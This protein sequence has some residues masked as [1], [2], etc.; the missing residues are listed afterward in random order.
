MLIKNKTKTKEILPH[1]LD[2][3]D[4]DLN[5]RDLKII[6]S[7]YYFEVII[8]E[9]SSDTENYSKK[10]GFRSNKTRHCAYIIY[11]V[12]TQFF[13]RHVHHSCIIKEY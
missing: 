13:N 7:Q 9:K 2:V 6:N 10:P 1:N 3:R 11:S 5:F 4:Q 12:K 8:I